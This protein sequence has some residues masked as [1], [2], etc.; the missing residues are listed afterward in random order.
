M[1]GNRWL[2]GII[3]AW[4]IWTGV[5][6]HIVGPVIFENKSFWFTA[7]FASATVIL[8]VAANLFLRKLVG[9]D[10]LNEIP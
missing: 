6:Y 3:A 7:G 9:K 1:N 4:L 10:A 8:S 2:I 5:R